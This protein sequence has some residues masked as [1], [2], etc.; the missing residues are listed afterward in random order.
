MINVKPFNSIRVLNICAQQHTVEVRPRSP[1]ILETS[2]ALKVTQY[3]DSPPVPIP[4][5]VKRGWGYVG[6]GCGG[7]WLKQFQT[8]TNRW[9]IPQPG[10]SGKPIIVCSLQTGS[11][12]NKWGSWSSSCSCQ[13]LGNSN[14]AP[15]S[16]TVPSPVACSWQPAGESATVVPTRLVLPLELT[17]MGRLSL[18]MRRGLGKS[19]R[20]YFRLRTHC[21][22]RVVFHKNLIR[23][24][25]CIIFVMDSHKEESPPPVLRRHDASGECWA[26]LNSLRSMYW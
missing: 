14:V 13:D 12:K 6:V 11:C 24:E 22:H 15:N 5:V 9:E 10:N 2:C 25:S 23:N 21:E 16:V 18:G 17:C 4:F 8:R 20:L 7:W 26:I 1:I 19:G 3:A